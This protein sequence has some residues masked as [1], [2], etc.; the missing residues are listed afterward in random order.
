MD[1][2][3][4]IREIPDFPKPGILFRDITPLLANGP[5]FSQTIDAL[6]K[7]ISDGKIDYVVGL[8]SRGFIFGA[9]VA[10]ALKCGFVPVRKQGKLPFKTIKQS[11]ELEYGTNTVE[12]HADAFPKKSRIAIVD[13]LLATGGTAQAAVQ[14]CEKLAAEI[15]GL[16][17]VVE[18]IDL[19]GRRRFPRHK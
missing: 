1:L 12:I 8:E 2:K 18:L 13:D 14:L 16:A 9:A 3:G 7:V 10:K 11:Y 17:F 4:Y 5:A 6:A 19:N 15:V